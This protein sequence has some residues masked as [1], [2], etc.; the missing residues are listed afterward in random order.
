MAKPTPIT[1]LAAKLRHIA[2]NLRQGSMLR[3]DEA[4][5]LN[6]AAG[7]VDESLAAIDVSELAEKTWRKAFLE[8][9]N[10]QDGGYA[11]E[12]IRT[13]LQQAAIKNETAAIQ[14]ERDRAAERTQWLEDFIRENVG[15]EADGA[16]KHR[17]GYT[18]A[19]DTGCCEVHDKWF[20]DE[21]ADRIRRGEG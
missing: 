2:A 7:Y 11:V 17:C 5:A 4:M 13:A 21:T 6:I 15:V 10:K 18:Y 3:T 8:A 9:T 19:P 12:I 14:R 16:P 1:E 20:T